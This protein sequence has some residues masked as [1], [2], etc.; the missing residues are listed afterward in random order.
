VI[1]LPEGGEVDAKNKRILS[2]FAHRRLHRRSPARRWRGKRKRAARLDTRWR[3]R[4]TQARRFE[5]V[6]ASC[7]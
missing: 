1:I 2:A 5:Q 6:V 7:H 3:H 4:C